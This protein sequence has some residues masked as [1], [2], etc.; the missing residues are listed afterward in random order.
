MQ[1]VR[2]L[3][4][5]VGVCPQGPDLVEQEVVF[6]LEVLD[7]FG[8]FGQDVGLVEAGRRRQP[9]EL[10]EVDVGDVVEHAERGYGVL[11]LDELGVDVC[12]V[13]L[14]DL[15][16]RGPALAAG[17]AGG[18][19]GSR[20]LLRRRKHGPQAW[21][22]GRRV[23]PHGVG[24]VRRHALVPA[25][26]HRV[27]RDVRERRGRL[28]RL[29]HH[30]VHVAAAAA[31]AA[32]FEAWFAGIV[33]IAGTAG[34]AGTVD[35]ADI[36]VS[37]VGSRLDSVVAVVVEDIAGIAGT[38]GIAGIAGTVGVAGRA[39]GGVGC[40]NAV[41]LYSVP[42]FEIVVGGGPVAGWR[43][44][45]RRRRRSSGC[46]YSFCCRRAWLLACGRTCRRCRAFPRPRRTE[47]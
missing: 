31:A 6:Q 32:A 46:F 37:S 40:E 35:T 26:V 1:A 45:G 29:V 38:V 2:R 19:G 7:V 24:R 15:V 47:G 9:F 14:L 43:P 3:V 27:W 18:G 8:G 28:P 36:V 41:I 21:R 10:V 13:L 5:V 30:G 17:H 11:Q 42:D 22:H 25:R 23:C 44:S 12:A 33:D 34:T 20:R 16:V 39:A 4:A